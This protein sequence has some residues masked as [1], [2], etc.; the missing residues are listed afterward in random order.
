MG[1]FPAGLTDRLLDQPQAKCPQG[2]DWSCRRM[3]AVGQE[4]EA[5]VEYTLA[6]WGFQLG[7]RVLR[8][9]LPDASTRRR[10]WY[11]RVWVQT[12]VWDQAQADT[13]RGTNALVGTGIGAFRHLGWC[14]SSP[15]ATKS[16]ADR[17][18][19]APRSIAGGQAMTLPP[20]G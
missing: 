11:S 15:V 1:L 20:A 19:R 8:Q 10:G 5:P 6:D 14:Q 12:P 16:V 9:G 4:P 2:L 13:R 18:K 17:A 7:W 3:G